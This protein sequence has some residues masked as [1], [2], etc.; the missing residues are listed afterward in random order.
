MRD[1]RVLNRLVELVAQKTGVMSVEIRGKCGQPRAV[2]ARSICFHWLRR[3]GWS[4]TQIGRAFDKDHTT[5]MHS[6]KHHPVSDS[7]L[8]GLSLE[9]FTQQMPQ[10]GIDYGVAARW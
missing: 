3:E 4:L 6:L 1:S 8:L 9:L 7:E 2:K 5:V 10:T